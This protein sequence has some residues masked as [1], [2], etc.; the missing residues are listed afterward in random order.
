MTGARPSD[1]R[2]PRCRPT[3]SASC[4]PAP[5]IARPSSQTFVSGL[6][7]L[8]ARRPELTTSR[9]IIYGRVADGA[10]ASRPRP[11]RVRGSRGCCPFHGFG[12]EPSPQLPL[13]MPTLPSS[14]SD[15]VPGWTYSSRASSTTTSARTGGPR[16]V[17]R[18]D[19]RDLLEGARLG[20]A[21]GPRAASS[22]PRRATDRRCR[23]RQARRTRKAGTTAPCSPVASPRSSTGRRRCR[24]C[25]RPAWTP[26]D[27]EG[28]GPHPGAPGVARWIAT[29]LFITIVMWAVILVAAAARAG[30][31]TTALARRIRLRLIL[32]VRYPFV[33]L[34][35]F[36]AFI[37][38]EDAA[39]SATSGRSA[40]M[41][42]SSSPSA[43]RSAGC[44]RSGRR[45]CRSRAG[46]FSDGRS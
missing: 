17:P 12:R 41:R 23:L 43:M 20:D 36:A 11:S 32:C 5:S 45:R 3:G 9:S 34:F 44:R 19:A 21:R 15:T 25:H 18:G 7:R 35:L 42:A 1:A 39:S 22:R 30:Q 27:D 2:R 26:R 38:I 46:R 24:D 4:T 14:S 31:L 6:D 33:P 8:A 16:D 28:H 10:G 37:P 40:A 13:R 29:Y